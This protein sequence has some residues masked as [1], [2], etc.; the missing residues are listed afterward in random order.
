MREE[1]IASVK[2]FGVLENPSYRVII[3]KYLV[4]QNKISVNTDI[5]FIAT[6][7][8]LYDYVQIKDLLYWLMQ[9]KLIKEGINLDKYILEFIDILTKKEV[10][11]HE[12]FKQA[13]VIN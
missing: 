11:K 7:Q 8:F 5:K 2:E 9:R 10:S 12:A 6:D 3:P 13:T 1:F 4:K